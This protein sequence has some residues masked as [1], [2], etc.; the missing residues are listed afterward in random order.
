MFLLSQFI[1]KNSNVD[2]ANISKYS[3]TMG[4]VFYTSLYLY[5]LPKPDSSKKS[6]FFSL[7]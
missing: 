3:I 5:I 4:L 2:P 1:L 6:A 7:K